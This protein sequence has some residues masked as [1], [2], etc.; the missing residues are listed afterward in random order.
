MNFS[1]Y[2]GHVTVFSRM[3]ITAFCLVVGLWLNLE[4]VLILVFGWLVVCTR[5]Y[6]TFRCHCHSPLRFGH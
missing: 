1:G 4:L 2:V 3:L 6:N 5:I